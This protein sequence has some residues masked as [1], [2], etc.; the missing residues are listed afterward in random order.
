MR[1]MFK[2]AGIIVLGL[3][4]L[5]AA[6][7]PFTIGTRPFIGPRSRALTDR[8]FEA[9]PGR[10]ERGRYLATS[11]NGCFACHS[12]LDWQANGFPAKAGTEGAGRVW[13]REGLPFL[14]AP[15][16]T[17]DVRTG[18]G[19]WTDD[20]LARAIREGIG[21]DGRTLFPVMPYSQY[22]SMSDEDLA[23]L[24]VYLRTIPAVTRD[25]PKSNIPFPVSRLINTLP[26]P[27]AA[28]VPQPNRHDATAYGDYLTRMGACRDCHTPVD[29]R[30]QPIAGM[31]F[32]GG[33]LLTGPYGQ[34][35]ARNLTPDPSGIPY[36]NADLFV[37]VMRTGMVKARKVHD[38]MPWASFGGQTDEDLRAIFQFLQTVRPVKHRVDNA[39][40]PTPCPVCGARHGAGDQN[41]PRSAT[42][43]SST[44]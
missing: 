6:A 23:S 16:I 20:M 11:V 25:L 2:I 24:I 42:T 13:D 12:E 17:P 3:S 22:R 31:E 38:A 39:L 33:F 4:T 41:V 21:H 14:T 40:P 34:V 32:S 1:R 37:E 15:N 26:E 5:G 36:Y 7:L 44:R 9:T 30:N 19:T 29:A 35:A 43:I 18:A 27:I 28:P 10:A 8:R